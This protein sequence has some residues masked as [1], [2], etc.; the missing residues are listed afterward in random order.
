MND[1]MSDLLVIL[2]ADYSAKSDMQLFM[3]I[4]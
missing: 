3:D 4:S 1:A 2:Y